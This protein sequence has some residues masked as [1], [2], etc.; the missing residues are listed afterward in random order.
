[1]LKKLFT[2]LFAAIFSLLNISAQKVFMLGD[3]HVFAKIYPHKT[4]E[5]IKD[6]FPDS[7]FEFW[8]KNGAEFVTY[9]ENPSYLQSL[10]DFNP[11]I[12]IVH[13]GTNDSYGKTFNPEYFSNSMEIFYSMIKEKMP[14]CK[15]ILVTPFINK[16]WLNKK[17]TKWKVN[18]KTRICSDEMTKFAESHPDTFIVDNNAEVGMSFL[19]N[20]RLIRP[21]NVHLTEAGYSL[22]GKQVADAAL[23]IEQIWQPFKN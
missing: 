21:D 13:L 17:R 4:E 3:S 23:S 22:L 5:L 2:L 18:D 16:R 1:M 12:L 15:I 8:G 19:K 14:E 6:A 20:R 10:F 7:Q 11:D 9:N